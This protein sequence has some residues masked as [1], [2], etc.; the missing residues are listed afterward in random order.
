MESNAAGSFT[1]QNQSMPQ[2][3]VRLAEL[4]DSGVGLERPCFE[5]QK[6]LGRFLQTCAMVPCLI[7][8][9]MDAIE[10]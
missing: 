3:L 8:V 6:R 2:S 7:I 1:Y 9:E 5:L 4:F 10:Y